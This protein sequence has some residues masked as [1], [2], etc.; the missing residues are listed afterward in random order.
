MKWFL[1]N[2]NRVVI[3]W[4]YVYETRIALWLA[5]YGWWLYWPVYKYLQKNGVCFVINIG[6]GT[7]HVLPELDNFFQKLRLGQI[8]GQRKYVWLRKTNDFSRACIRLYGHQFA[9]AAVSTWLYDLA[10]P[11]MYRWKDITLDSGVS[12]LH[13]ELPADGK[14]F[15][16]PPWQTF[17]Y[18][19]PKSE[20]LRLWREYYERRAVKPEFAPMV[21]Y[22]GEKLA[23]DRQLLAFLDKRTTKLALIHIKTNVM[24]ATAATT[25][26]A[27]YLP[28]MHHFLA[29][30]Y[31]LVF[32]GREKMPVEFKD[33]PMLNYAESLVAS[34]EHDLQLF[35]L[36]DISITGGSGIAWI[37]DVLN[38]PV[39]YV[40]SWHIFMPPFNPK[41]VFVPTLVKKKGGD[42]LSFYEQFE[43]YRVVDPS[44]GDK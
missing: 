22:A 29:Q 28:A 31:A 6:E 38:K 1:V 26:P 16:S 23:P 25:D 15:I 4:Q 37:A 14:Y 27:T 18:M 32:V 30:G 3:V 9:Y 40:N 39:L 34:F 44:R 24:N 11:I 8:D 19:A 5:L 10:L 35:A 17:L 7:G 41:C 42:L 13:W 33:V 36:A 43:L 21:E 20:A 2:L 12:A